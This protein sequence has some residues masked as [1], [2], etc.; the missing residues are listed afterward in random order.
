MSCVLFSDVTDLHL[1]DYGCFIFND[2]GNYWIDLPQKVKFG[3]KDID[4]N[5]ESNICKTKKQKNGEFRI[6]VILVYCMYF[7]CIYFG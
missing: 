4:T 7:L 5:G 2:F 1:K 6:D 3:N